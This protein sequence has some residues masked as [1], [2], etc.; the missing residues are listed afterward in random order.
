MKLP[1]LHDR[2]YDLLC[3]IDD[4]AKKENVRYFLDSGTA[5]GAAREGDFIPWDDDMDLKVLAEDYPAFKAA[6]EKNLPEH[7][8]LAEP[9][10]RMPAFYDFIVRIYDDRV[11][12]RELT[13]EDRYYK[14]FVNHLGTDIF[15][16]AK[17]PKSEFGK[18]W[19][20]LRIKILFGLGMS[21]RYS[22]DYSKYSGI[23]KAQVWV[24][25][26]LGHLFPL[27]FIHKRKQALTHRY[28]DVTDS[29][30]LKVDVNPKDLRF[31]PESLYAGEITLPLR[32]RE[33]PAISGYKE[34]L[35]LIY[36]EDW[37]TPRRDGDYIRHL[38]EQDRQEEE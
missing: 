19:M 28:A 3:V 13:E 11:P 6:M 36:G 14:D 12:I 4:I 7:L 23:Q 5:L 32:G 1:E 18:K 26:T 25:A 21:R 31:Y 16:M 22:I 35:A 8:H 33:F 2:L 15:V 24:L 9:T 17:T 20:R 34:E 10:E 30:R 38:D 27:S 29:C 37:M